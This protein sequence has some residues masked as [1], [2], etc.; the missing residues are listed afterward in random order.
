M[1]SNVTVLMGHNPI[2]I[3]FR[4]LIPL[5]GTYSGIKMVFSFWVNALEMKR[6]KYCL[7][8]ISCFYILLQTFMPLLLCFE[9]IHYCLKIIIFPVSHFYLYII[10]TPTLVFVFRF[11]VNCKLMLHV[12]ILVII[13]FSALASG[14]LVSIAILKH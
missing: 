7:I 5:E 11:Y 1:Y 13:I 9:M 4:H 8:Y 3:Y 14:S 2:V 10:N 6:R 12:N